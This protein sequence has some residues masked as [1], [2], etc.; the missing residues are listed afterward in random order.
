MLL[1]C[2][3]SEQLRWLKTAQI[4]RIFAKF[5]SLTHANKSLWDLL[6]SAIF[7]IFHSWNVWHAAVPRNR[8]YKADFTSLLQGRKKPLLRSMNGPNA[9]LLA[10]KII[11]NTCPLRNWV[12]GVPCPRQ[13]HIWVG[14]KKWQGPL[15]LWRRALTERDYDG[16][17]WRQLPR[18]T[19][20]LRPSQR[21]RWLWCG[22][23]MWH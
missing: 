9:E 8:P 18:Q 15:R 5:T 10:S 7:E 2:S 14:N 17:I 23:C 21:K 6:Q 22:L 19:R 12:D 4:G 16:N 3:Y 13:K 1:Q 11:K 20:A